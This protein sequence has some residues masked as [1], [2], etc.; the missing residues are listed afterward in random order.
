MEKEYLE[1]EMWRCY[2]PLASHRTSCGRH[3]TFLRCWSRYQ[4]SFSDESAWTFAHKARLYSSGKRPFSEFISKSEVLTET[5]LDSHHH[6]R[7]W[8]DSPWWAL[9]FLRSFAH[10]SRL[11]ATFFQFL[12]PNIL[13][14]WSTPS[15]HRNFDLPTHLAPSG[16][17]LN[18]FYHCS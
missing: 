18:I 4:D 14:A 6:H 3:V 2:I 17:V 10:S 13:I 7:H 8:F 15:S 16:L 1:V 9:A 5:L 11:R 12:T